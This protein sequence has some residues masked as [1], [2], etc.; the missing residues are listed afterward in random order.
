MKNKKKTKF[1]ESVVLGPKKVVLDPNRLA[2]ITKR[3]EDVLQSKNDP[4][5]RKPGVTCFTPRKAKYRCESCDITFSGHQGPSQGFEM[6][7]GEQVDIPTSCPNCK[8]LYVVW[9]NYDEFV[10]SRSVQHI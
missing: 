9:T 7:D 5:L 10:V 1:K 8:S 6:V 2:E 4:W 3:V